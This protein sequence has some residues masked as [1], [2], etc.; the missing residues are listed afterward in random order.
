[1]SFLSGEE[2]VVPSNVILPAIATRAS[3]SALEINNRDLT[4]IP[5]DKGQI[6]DL[7]FFFAGSPHFWY[8]GTKRV[9]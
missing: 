5:H 8:S 7:L 1:M 9:P 2:R 4:P 6:D 3:R